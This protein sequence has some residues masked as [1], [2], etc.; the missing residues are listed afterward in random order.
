M[1]RRQSRR[2][3]EAA[4]AAPRR[5]LAGGRGREGR[6]GRRG[7]CVGSCA[8]RRCRTR[9]A[10]GAPRRRA[11]ARSR[12]PAHS[13]NAAAAVLRCTARARMA[14]AGAPARRARARAAAPP[15]AREART[16][17][18]AAAGGA[19][20]E[21][22]EEGSGAA[23]HV[24][25]GGG[26]GR[27]IESGGG[28][29]GAGSCRA[30]AAAGQT[31][32][33]TKQVAL[34][35]LRHAQQPP[36]RR[37]RLAPPQAAHMSCMRPWARLARPVGAVAACRGR[38]KVF[39][40]GSSQRR[41][42]AAPP[43][44]RGRTAGASRRCVRPVV[45]A[46]CAAAS[47]GAFAA[48]APAARPQHECGL[49]RR[50]PLLVLVVE[51]GTM[52]DHI[53]TSIALARGGTVCAQF[54]RP[55]VLALAQGRSPGGGG[56]AAAA[57]ATSSAVCR[58]GRPQ[59]RQRAAASAPC[60]R[61]EISFGGE[62]PI[63]PRLCARCHRPSRP[64]GALPP[65]AG[66]PR[67]RSRAP[68]WPPAAGGQAVSR[69]GR[70]PGHRACTT[71]CDA[72]A[73]AHGPAL[74]PARSGPTRAAPCTQPTLRGRRHTYAALPCQGPAGVGARTCWR[75][76]AWARGRDGGGRM[77]RG[78][79]HASGA[80]GDANTTYTTCN[81]PR[82]RRHAGT[83]ISSGP[84]CTC[85]GARPLGCAAMFLRTIRINTTG[86]RPSS[87]SLAMPPHDPLQT[88]PAPGGAGRRETCPQTRAGHAV[89]GKR[90][91]G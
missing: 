59:R 70:A 66:R 8:A 16:R 44:A 7:A 49:E 74:P 19:Q 2:R 89:C 28:R 85:S 29:W 5:R 69:V 62:L 12:A 53:N 21:E 51:Q 86:W 45:S 67:S 87:H 55:L 11:P 84:W 34:P 9:G 41:P 61:A 60:G 68:W 25:A 79:A 48:G 54:C 56:G 15:R 39:T 73:G 18:G 37:R 14:R 38:R 83:L 22:G 3:P 81:R 65:A 1:R 43:C 72:A 13:R 31:Q 4:G 10:R 26:G 76:H 90:L 78:C 77:V 47:T 36:P 24:C 63:D 88:R 57:R 46:T 33:P 58:C 40:A 64:A 71:Q 50:A 32:L 52:L 17:R 23:S 80:L 27:S 91:G 42:Q 75:T 30:L 35:P 6:A 82:A 20:R